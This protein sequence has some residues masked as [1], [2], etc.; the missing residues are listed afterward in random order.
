MYKNNKAL[1]EKD[2]SDNLHIYGWAWHM[3][4]NH[5]QVKNP[6]VALLNPADGNKHKL[7]KVCTGIHICEGK[8][9]AR[10][11]MMEITIH[12]DVFLLIVWFPINK[13][14]HLASLS[15]LFPSLGEFGWLFLGWMGVRLRDWKLQVYN[16]TYPPTDHP[17]LREGPSNVSITLASNFQPTQRELAPS[18]T[19][20]GKNLVGSFLQSFSWI[21]VVLI[22]NPILI[23]KRWGWWWQVN[24]ILARRF[25][26]WQYHFL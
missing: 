22:D 10:F 2:Q 19:M 25:I 7:S 5:N 13:Y 23:W 26:H 9:L 24:D 14:H 4:E 20:P 3:V 8:K 11:L 18:W 21:W 16:F 6:T 1:E 17:G 12:G 15:G